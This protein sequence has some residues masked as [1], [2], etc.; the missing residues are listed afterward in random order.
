MA[1]VTQQAAVVHSYIMEAL[2]VL[3]ETNQGMEDLTIGNILTVA[4]MIQTEA[5][6]KDSPHKD[7][8]FMGNNI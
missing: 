1:T 4:K 6:R 5:L 2:S 3:S 8:P 7:Y